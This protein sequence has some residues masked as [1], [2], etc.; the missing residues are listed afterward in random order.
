MDVPKRP[1]AEGSLAPIRAGSRSL[2]KLFTLN[3]ASSH[4]VLRKA[5][6]SSISDSTLRSLTRLLRP[7]RAS[8][9]STHTPSRQKRLHSIARSS[10]SIWRRAASFADHACI[11]WFTSDPVSFLSSEKDIRRV[12]HPWA[13]HEPRALAPGMFRVPCT[14]PRSHTS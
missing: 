1:A 2:N 4:P 3:F 10:V 11:F 12:L 13:E 14:I 9:S 5:I 6:F 8:S 7:D